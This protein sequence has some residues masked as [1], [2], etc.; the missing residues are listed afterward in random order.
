M[1]VIHLVFLLGAAWLLAVALVITVRQPPSRRT[2][3]G[4]DVPAFKP[5]PANHPIEADTPP[6]RH[7]V[8]D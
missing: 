2:E 8:R 5:D 6:P 4:A 7:T 1:A 3:R